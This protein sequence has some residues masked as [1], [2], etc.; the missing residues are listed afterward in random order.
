MG[1]VGMAVIKALQK[2]HHLLD[3]IARVRDLEADSKKLAAYCSA[4]MIC[5][6][7]FCN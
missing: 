3:I 1:N 4:L 2:Q 7:I 5:S 6:S